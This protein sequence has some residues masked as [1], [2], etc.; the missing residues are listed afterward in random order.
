MEYKYLNNNEVIPMIKHL[1]DPKVRLYLYNII[2]A[3][4][5]LLVV[6]GILVEEVS[7][8]WLAVSGA[9]LGIVGAELASQNVDVDVEQPI[10]EEDLQ[11]LPTGE[12]PVAHELGDLDGTD[13]Y[14]S[15]EA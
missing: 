10:T 9:V 3:V 11:E 2:K 7:A 14:P 4:I 13:Q 5:P 8:L 12:Y 15:Q 1:Q 6:A